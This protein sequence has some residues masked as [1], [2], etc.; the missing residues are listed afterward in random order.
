MRDGVKR[1]KA[2]VIKAI[3]KSISLGKGMNLLSI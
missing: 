2:F 1:S 3:E